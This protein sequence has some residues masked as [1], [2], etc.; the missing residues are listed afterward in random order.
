MEFTNTM[1]GFFHLSGSARVSGRVN[2]LP[3]NLPSGVRM[4]A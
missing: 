4:L 1:R 2:A 3:L